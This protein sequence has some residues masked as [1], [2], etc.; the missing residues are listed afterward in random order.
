M[1]LPALPR[2]SLQAPFGVSG[3]YSHFTDEGPEAQRGSN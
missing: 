1:S 2:S 3:D